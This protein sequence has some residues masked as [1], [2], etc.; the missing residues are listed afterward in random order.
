MEQGKSMSI[1]LCREKGDDDLCI[2][3]S[4]AIRPPPA[5]PCINA[6]RL[7][8]MSS[9]RDEKSPQTITLAEKG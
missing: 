8:E 9:A 2:S 3:Y 1:E 4:I 7:L 5:C 6:Q